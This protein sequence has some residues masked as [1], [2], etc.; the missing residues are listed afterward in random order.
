V[1][2]PTLPVA[3]G[4]VAGP[5]YGRKCKSTLHFLLHSYIVCRTSVLL[6]DRHNSLFKFLVELCLKVQSTPVFT[7]MTEI[8]VMPV[9]TSVLC[10]LYS[11]YTLLVNMYL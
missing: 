5:K 6:L 4:C 10:T 9:N 7:G 3:V 11:L 8:S 2:W 1:L